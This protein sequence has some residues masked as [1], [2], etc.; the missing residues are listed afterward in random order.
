M[1]HICILS[2]S[3]EFRTEKQEAAVQLAVLSRYVTRENRNRQCGSVQCRSHKTET[4][5]LKIESLDTYGWIATI[6][7]TV[8]VTTL[9][10]AA[11]GYFF[12]HGVPFPHSSEARIV[13]LKCNKLKM[14]FCSLICRTTLLW[15]LE[16]GP[17]GISR[18][19]GT[20]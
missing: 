19:N 9:G 10:H 4:K 1:P 14:G 16:L 6:S 20:L 13:R 18:P 15:P 11:N 5:V 17:C 2:P 8:W 7:F 12:E 3:T